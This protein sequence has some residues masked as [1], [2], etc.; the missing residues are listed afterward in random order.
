MAPGSENKKVDEQA[1][2]GAHYRSG[3][4]SFENFGRPAGFPLQ[5]IGNLSSYYKPLPSHRIRAG[6]FQSGYFRLNVFDDAC[7]ETRFCGRL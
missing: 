5:G 4:R 3:R 1:D 6:T 2:T 7:R